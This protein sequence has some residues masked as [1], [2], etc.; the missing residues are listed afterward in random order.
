MTATYADDTAILTSS[1]K[2][3]LAS[4]LLQLQLDKVQIWME[5]WRI[6]AS[7]A[8]SNHITFSLRRGDCP[9]VRLNNKN[10]PDK[11][12]VRYLGMHLDR[13]LT[14][15]E[16]IKI[17]RTELNIRLGKL[18]WLIG[19]QSTL[20]LQNK[21]LVYSTMLKPLWTYGLELWGTASSSNLEILQ[22]F[23]NKTLRIMVNAPWFVR[24]EEVHEHAQIPFVK[25]VIRSS[26]TRYKDRLSRHVNILA[27]D[28]LN[29]AA[30]TRR[31]KR[32]HALDLDQ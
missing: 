8:K 10:L 6:R 12:V 25:E 1:S 18:H 22:R 24:N 20:T 14:W 5:K 3:E 4:A 13:H 11:K 17:K 21:L 31:L 16:H 15:K 29:N 26:S 19:R 28:L 30:P 23:Q 2:S 27:S 32:Q 9:S 7:A